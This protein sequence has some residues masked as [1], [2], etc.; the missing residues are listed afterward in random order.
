MATY[1]TTPEVFIDG[2]SA[3]LYYAAYGTSKVTAFSVDNNVKY[4]GTSSMRFEVP[5]KGDPNGSY[6][7]GVFGTNPGRDLSGYNVLTF[8]A[9][10]SQPAI[11]NEVGFGNDMG[12]SKYKV[13]LT[14]V[15]VNSNWMKYYVPFP[16]PSVLKQERGM[17]FYSAAPQNGRGYTF[18][19]DEVQFEN[20]GTIAHTVYSICNG[21]DVKTSG[22]MGTY[23]I[24]NFNAKFN[25]PTG[26][27]L[28]ETISNLY[29]TFKSSDESIATVN[30][31]GVVNLIGNG[32]AKI[33]AKVGNTDAIGSF[34]VT[35]SG[36]TS[37]APTPAVDPA[38]ALSIY[39]DAY[40][41]IPIEDYCE[42]WEWGQGQ[43]WHQI[44]TTEYSFSSMNGNNFIHYSNNNDTWGLKR[45]I[46]PIKFKSNPQNVS[47]MTYVHIDVWVPAASAY[48]T[49][50][51]TIALQD[52]SG[53]Q[54]GVTR[55]TS[56]PTDQ[57]VSIEIALSGFPGI[58]KT[59]VAYFVL[60]NFPSRYL[61]R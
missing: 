28:T 38:N 35:T 51:P 10:A 12:E 40:T 37:S 20:L 16:D 19:I 39:S 14:N 11:L 49:N 27:D 52:L 18:W 4:K 45:V 1:P 17:F 31:A 48:I 22:P 50:K 61:C 42:H 36:P 32:T 44:I 21:S 43:S 58:D 53:A 56:L 47:S 54:V 5:D 34:T 46:A 25:Q 29:F 8:W 7:G 55:A 60:D 26:A 30:S 24:T 2:F 15:A 9:K 6:V 13:T 3:G 33:T 57:W 41:N 23:T 59:K